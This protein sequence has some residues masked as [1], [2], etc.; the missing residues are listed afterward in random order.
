[1]LTRSGPIPTRGEWA[2]EV[3]W[4]GFR[5]IASTQGTLGVRSRRGWDV[6]ERVLS[7]SSLPART[8]LDGELLA[9]DAALNAH[10]LP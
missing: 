9:L 6:T 2:F 3:K 1:M 8:V 10:A 4:D 7:L 5:A